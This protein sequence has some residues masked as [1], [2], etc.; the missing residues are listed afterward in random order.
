ME[1]YELFAF[2]T[3]ESGS[4]VLELGPNWL[5]GFSFGKEG[6]IYLAYIDGDWVTETTPWLPTPAREGSRHEG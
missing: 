2:D 3:K 1:A 6:L 4:A 5:V